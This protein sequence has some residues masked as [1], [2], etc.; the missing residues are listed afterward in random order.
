MYWWMIG[1]RTYGVWG[2]LNAAMSRP[3]GSG[4]GKALKGAERQ[5]GSPSS[6]SSHWHHTMAVLPTQDHSSCSQGLSVPSPRILEV[7]SPAPSG[8]RSDGP[9][10]LLATGTAP[11]LWVLLASSF[12]L[13]A[14]SLF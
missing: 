6:Y 9:S 2:G 10:L 14:I 8:L 11:S 4:Q 1:P 5:E 7:Q 3:G 12:V 13:L